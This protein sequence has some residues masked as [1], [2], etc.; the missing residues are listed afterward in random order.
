MVPTLI[1]IQLKSLGNDYDHGL[2]LGLGH[3]FT[4]EVSNYFGAFHTASI[5]YFTLPPRSYHA[6]TD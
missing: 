1:T 3:R 6:T 5:K 4:A 2:G